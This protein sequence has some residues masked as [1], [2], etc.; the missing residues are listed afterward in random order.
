MYGKMVEKQVQVAGVISG[1]VIEKY[2]IK[3]AISNSK[4]S[5]TF[6]IYATKFAEVTSLN[7]EIIEDH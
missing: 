7:I 3:F 1:K 4:N 6:P 5:R 2:Y